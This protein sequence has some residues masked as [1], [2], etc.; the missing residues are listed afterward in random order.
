MI[1]P[2]CEKFNVWNQNGKPVKVVRCDNAGENTKLSKR[3]NSHEWKLN[4]QFEFTGRDTPQQNSLVEVGFA[5]LASRGRAMM[6][7]ANV[8]LLVRYKVY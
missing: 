3:C 7:N 6:I 1:E 8:P 2:T 4:I 5:T